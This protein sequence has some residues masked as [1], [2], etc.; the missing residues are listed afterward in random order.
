MPYTIKKFVMQSFDTNREA[1]EFIN[2]IVDRPIHDTVENLGND[3]A[4]HAF[5]Q[6]LG[7]S[8]FT[9]VYEL[10]FPSSNTQPDIKLHRQPT[11]VY[12]HVK[13][14]PDIRAATGGG[15]FFLADQASAKP[16][17]SALNLAVANKRIYSLPV[18]DREAVLLDNGQ[19]STEHL[20]AIGAVV[21]N[22]LDLSWSGSLT[23][24]VTDTKVYSNG[25]SI[26]THIKDD[27]VGNIR[28]LDESSRYTPPIITDDTIDIGFINRQNGS[29]A[30]VTSSNLGGIDIYNHDIV[31][32][33]HE[34]HAHK[35]LPTMQIK[36]IGN[37]TLDGTLQSAISVG[38]K[39][40]V[41]NFTQH[42][43]NSDLSLGSKP[44]FL[45][46]P[47]ARTILYKTNDERIHIRLFDGRPGSSIF[48]GITPKHAAE[49]VLNSNN[50]EWGCFLDPGQTA[51]L[52]IRDD[53][54]IITSYGN[55]HYLKWPDQP[56][57]KYTWTP[58]T[59]RPTAS[60]LTFV[61]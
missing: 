14:Q 12:D 54:E 23:E 26:I 38:P 20:R 60:M 43:I 10:S 11:S 56:G 15:F 2:S 19:L 46:I 44:P 32:R 3:M 25:N 28:V 61:R 31:M 55:T 47:L 27:L 4:L 41:K 49:S 9:N 39:V 36:T 30:G 5:T 34:R 13:S 21:V 17:Q 50:L 42:P 6:D 40:D 29:F 51:K 35:A 53:E 18:S 45:D 16:R 48:P 58:K 33:M 24:Y 57:G 1:K 52:V 59:G 22:S 37:R 8:R 7:E